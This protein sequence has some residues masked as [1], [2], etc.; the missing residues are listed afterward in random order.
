MRIVP[1]ALLLASSIWR[2]AAETDD[3]EEEVQTKE[4]TYFGGKKVP[5]LLELT[6]DNFEKESKKAE[7]LMVKHY[8]FVSRAVLDDHPSMLTCNPQ[9]ILSPLYRLCADIPNAVRILLHLET[10]W[11]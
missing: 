11:R 5:P 4:N 3:G 6:P 1:F 7:W 2:V 8:K 10:H 9:P